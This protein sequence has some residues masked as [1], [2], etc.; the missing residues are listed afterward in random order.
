MS[1]LRRIF[2]CSRKANHVFHPR[3]DISQLAAR[4]C[5]K[6]IKPA[7]RFA[8]DWIWSALECVVCFGSRCRTMCGCRAVDLG[9]SVEKNF[10]LKLDK[11]F[12]VLKSQSSVGGGEENRPAI[13]KAPWEGILLQT[14]NFHRREIVLTRFT[15]E[16]LDWGIILIHQ[17]HRLRSRRWQN[18]FQWRKLFGLRMELK[19]AAATRL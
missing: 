12:L 18:I 19:I 7:N 16:S 13:V 5:R 2:S 4:I 15:W 9:G 10:S 1:E 17:T 14:A 3:H 6:S 8:Q 11:K